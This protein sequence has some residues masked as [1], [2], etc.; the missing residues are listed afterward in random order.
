MK[1]TSQT[2]LVKPTDSG[3]SGV[4]AEVN[5]AQA[6]WDYLNMAAMRLRRGESYQ[7]DTRE[8]ENATV[9]LGGVL[10]YRQQRWRFQER[11]QAAR[12]L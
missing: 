8:H 10:R 9:I 5:A 11:G 3:G 12:C 2:M 6:G 4:F 1:Y 7:V